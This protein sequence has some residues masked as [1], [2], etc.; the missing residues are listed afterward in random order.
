MRVYL[1]YVV[2]QD[3]EFDQLAGVYATREG[4]EAAGGAAWL[5]RGDTEWTLPAQRIEEWEVGAP[6]LAFL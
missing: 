4:A 3:R 6:P 1:L 2:S 5:D